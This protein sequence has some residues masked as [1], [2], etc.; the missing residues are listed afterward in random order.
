ME[1]KIEVGEFVRTREGYIGILID[2]NMES[3]NYLTI[4]CK[5]RVRR[6]FSYP[7][8]YLY[9]KDEDI[10]KHSKNIIDI[11]EVGDYVNGDLVTEVYDEMVECLDG[12]VEYWENEIKTIVTHEQFASVEYKV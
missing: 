6:D 4:D 10:V 8:S 2:I 1:D 3:W 12:E 7:D 9:L 11:I 5:R